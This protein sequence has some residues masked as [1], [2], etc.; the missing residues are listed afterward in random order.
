MSLI[1]MISFVVAAHSLIM[2][3]IILVNPSWYESKAASSGVQPNIFAAITIK[4]I[5]AAISFSI[6]YYFIDAH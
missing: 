4:L 6:G 3:L 1:S 5:L 2:V